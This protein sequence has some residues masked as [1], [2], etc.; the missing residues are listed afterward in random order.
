MGLFGKKKKDDQFKAALAQAAAKNESRPERDWQP[1]P[2]E[3]VELGTIHYANLTQDGRH[4]EY[5]TALDLA[6]ETGRPIFANF[7]EWSGWQG[8][9]D[10][11]KI[12]ADPIVKRAAEELFV[13]CAFNTWDRSDSKLSIPM[14][15]WGAG[16]A[17]S[18]WGYLR[19]IDSEG[20]LVVSGTRQITSHR[21]LDEVKQVMREALEDLGLD[22]PDY[23]A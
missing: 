9:K 11:G 7:V 13:P 8:C 2:R 12:F 1:P 15:K 23:L 6:A 19:I 14:K 3:F 17:S 10:A 18:W 4:G 16:L 5:Q 21:Q 22:V 20:K